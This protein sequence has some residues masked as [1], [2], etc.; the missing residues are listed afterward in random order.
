MYKLSN[1]SHGTIFVTFTHASKI[2]TKVLKSKASTEL[3]NHQYSCLDMQDSILKLLKIT[4]Y[5]IPSSRVTIKLYNPI[6]MNIP[7]S[8]HNQSK[9]SSYSKTIQSKKSIIIEYE[10]YERIKDIPSYI[11]VS[12][13]VDHAI[14]RMTPHDIT[15]HLP[16]RIAPQTNAQA[17]ITSVAKLQALAKATAQIAEIKNEVIESPTITEE[18]KQELPPSE[19]LLSGDPVVPEEEDMELDLVEDEEVDVEDPAMDSYIADIIVENKTE[20][21]EEKKLSKKE[22]RRQGR[23]Q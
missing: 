21:K 17:P 5:N 19:L 6:G 4:K 2:A 20:V 7:V 22:K 12:E 23:S 13:I 14:T 18:P 9:T 3:S 11:Q 10:E 16:D 15:K 1:T 8:F